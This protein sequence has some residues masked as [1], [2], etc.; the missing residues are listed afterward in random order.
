MIMLKS[1]KTKDSIEDINKFFDIIDSS[2]L[3]FKE[4][5]KNY[6]YN[7]IEEFNTNLSEISRKE[8]DINILRREIELSLHMQTSLVKYRADIMRLLEG[9]ESIMSTMNDN[10]I[11]FEI[12]TP[13]VPAELIQHF[14]K[15]T[16]LSTLSI[17]CV[18][19]AARV[20]F[21]MPNVIPEKVQR[22]YFYDREVNKIAQGLKRVVFRD[23]PT[24]KLSEKFH[25][26]YFTLHIED[27]GKESAKVAD[28]L[29]VMSLKRKL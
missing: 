21:T 15:L 19:S 29:S 22:V 4:G 1:K 18:I 12:E 11:Q 7:N 2:L 28:L 24:L 26:R 10:I 5:V 14:I 16:D 20:Y 25:L 23:M 8:T 3:I 6:L 9:I 27:L 13:T 17:E